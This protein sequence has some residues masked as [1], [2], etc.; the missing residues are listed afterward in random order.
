MFKHL[1]RA[2][3]LLLPTMQGE[4]RESQLG[5]GREMAK[6]GKQINVFQS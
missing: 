2:I 3:S 1:V 5:G 4:K 6:I